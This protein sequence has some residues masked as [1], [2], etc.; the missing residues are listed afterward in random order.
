MRSMSKENPILAH[1]RRI[2][3]CARQHP[4]AVLLVAL[5]ASALCFEAV[6]G[7]TLAGSC[8]QAVPLAA[9]G[10]VA[11]ACSVRCAL[12]AQRSAARACALRRWAA[13]VLAV[14]LV[15]GVA[16]AVAAGA[17][18]SSEV[19][20]AAS[21]AERAALVVLLCLL[22]G[23]FEEGV[24]RVAAFEA[25]AAAFEPRAK[26][27]LMAAAASSVLFGVLHVSLGDVLAAGGVAAVQLAAKP[28]Q[29]A[30]FGFFMTAIFVRT[31]SLWS[32]AGLHGTFN[33]LY[34]GPGLLL[35]GRPQLSYAT[36]STA[37]LALLLVTTALLV[38][39]AVAACK[40]IASCASDNARG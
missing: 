28:V 30:L 10:I 22:T 1:G 14:G 24:F 34:L 26:A 35:T 19:P 29:A 11:A 20:N 12:A 21:M 40:S 15:G 27:A 4:L 31:R 25:F 9:I 36:G 13:Y 38:P 23:V 8:V 17:S 39:P 37:D 16:A 33:L 32:V 18:P 3:R 5:V 6:P 2:L 7:D